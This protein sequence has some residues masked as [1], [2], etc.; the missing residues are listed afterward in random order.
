MAFY[1]DESVYA[2]MLPM[3]EQSVYNW[4]KGDE[5]TLREMVGSRR[6]NELLQMAHGRRLGHLLKAAVKANAVPIV[7]TAKGLEN[8]WRYIPHSHMD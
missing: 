7:R 3:I 8:T 5:K 1:T 4:E 6:Y 2:V